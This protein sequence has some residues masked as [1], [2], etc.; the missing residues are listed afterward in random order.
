[1]AQTPRAIDRTRGPWGFGTGALATTLIAIV[2]PFTT[3]AGASLG[4][5][6]TPVGAREVVGC[7]SGSGSAV[8]AGPQSHRAVAL[9]FDDGPSTAYTPAILAILDRLHASATFF[10]EGHHVAGREALMR[11][12]LASGDEIANHTFD[13]PRDP[14]FEELAAT[15]R[16]IHAA[17]GFTPCL[18]RPPYGL[19][20]AKVESATRRNDLQTVLWSVDSNDDKHPGA[21]AI[22]S[23]V[24]SLAR[25][26]SIVLMHDGGH[27]PQT[28][29][30]LPGIVRGLY[31]R[32]FNLVT[33]TRL[34]GGHFVYRG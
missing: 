11:R 15:N 5:G 21:G 23:R 31:A 3:S 16:L 7:T 32:G 24:L 6:G 9:T 28:V 1:M 8:A 4:S 33:V 27:H 14:G 12:I 18:F 13:H 30:A 20:D 26:G 25:P 22:R 34:L 29:A 2:A 10:E 19:I 17:T